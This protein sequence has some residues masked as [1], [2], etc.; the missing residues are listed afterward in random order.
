MRVVA[1]RETLLYDD[2]GGFAGLFIYYFGWRRRGGRE[3]TGY[4][5]DCV[6][7]SFFPDHNTA[8]SNKDSTFLHRMDCARPRCLEAR[9]MFQHRRTLVLIPMMRDSFQENHLLNHVLGLD[10]DDHGSLPP[11]GLTNKRSTSK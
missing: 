5:V 7:L 4:K 9:G 6:I 10:R 2:V 1:V 11:E 3:A 8:G